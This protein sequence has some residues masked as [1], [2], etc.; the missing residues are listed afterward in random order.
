MNMIYVFQ[1]FCSDNHHLNKGVLF[2]GLIFNKFFGGNYL[3][4][5]TKNLTANDFKRGKK[6]CL[7]N[8]L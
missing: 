2:T 3:F 6:E 1:S 7:L 4:F 5:T 8:F